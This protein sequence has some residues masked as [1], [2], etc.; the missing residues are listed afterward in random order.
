MT[1]QAGRSS[2]MNAQARD[3]AIAGASAGLVSSVVTCPLDVI[4]TRLQVMAEPGTKAGFYRVGH[5]ISRIW[6][7]DGLRGYYRGLVPTMVG[8]LPTW[9]IYFVVY[10]KGKTF[11][12]SQ[13]GTGGKHDFLIHIC[14]AMT[15]GVVSTTCTSPFWVV[16]TRTMPSH[17]RYNNIL[18]AFRKIYLREGL[19]GFYKGLLP[20]L[21]GVFHVVVQFPLYEYFKSLAATRQH[22]DH[23]SPTMILLCSGGSKMLASMATYPHEVLRTRLQM[24]PQSGHAHYTGLFQ[25]ISVI[26]QREGI[27]GFY[28]GMG[29]NLIRTVPNSGLTLLTYEVIM[30]RLEA[31]RRPP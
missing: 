17:Q 31:M 25:A 18:D 11:F 15:A 2:H 3:S 23:L 5:I 13:I 14:S 20:S 30:G 21:L 27:R 29:V 26:F 28:K 19:G 7:D 4:K 8:Y 12:S 9:A 10:D 22:S 16:K 6:H 1:S 24:V